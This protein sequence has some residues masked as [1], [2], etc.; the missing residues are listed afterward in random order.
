MASSAENLTEFLRK[1]RKEARTREVDWAVVRREWLE[2][3]EK[4]GHEIRGWLEEPAAEKLIAVTPGTIEL[5][6]ETLGQYVA[7]TWEIRAASRVISV[8]PV[9]RVIIGGQG[10][11]DLRC[12]PRKRMLIR[13][14][15]GTWKLHERDERGLVDPGQELDRDTFSKAIHDLLS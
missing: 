8:V 11:V 2:D 7:P 3:L 5:Q 4:L 12:G 9:G 6:E 14:G 10:R 13:S 15:K 1:Q